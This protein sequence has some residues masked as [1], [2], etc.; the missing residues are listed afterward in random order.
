MTT[1]DQV[2][3]CDALAASDP[4]ATASS[5]ISSFGLRLMAW[6]DT[7]AEYYAAAAMYEQLSRL[8]DS[9]LARRGLSRAALA[10][11]ACN[12]GLERH[13]PL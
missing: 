5:W 4:A 12:L 7:C 9:E 2:L 13:A 10:R 11:A 3:A 6:A 8:S 1:H